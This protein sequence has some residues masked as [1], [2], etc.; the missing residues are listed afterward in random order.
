MSSRL[1]PCSRCARISHAN[2]KKD[3]RVIIFDMKT[4]L[5]R[6]F[7]PRTAAYVILDHATHDWWGW[8][9]TETMRRPWRP[10]GSWGATTT[11]LVMSNHID[12]RNLD[13]FSQYDTRFKIV[14]ARKPESIR[15]TLLK[16]LE[17]TYAVRPPVNWHWQKNRVAPINYLTMKQE[18]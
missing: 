6:G 10:W 17:V 13:F 5:K 14:K 1:L 18:Y 3:Q 12:A 9:R 2:E 11:D 8:C 15:S 4:W 7:A 16:P